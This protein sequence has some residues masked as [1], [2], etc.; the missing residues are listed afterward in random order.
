MMKKLEF[1]EYLCLLLLGQNYS[2]NFYYG[3]MWI[4]KLS[5]L[6]VRMILCSITASIQIAEVV[7]ALKTICIATNLF[8]LEPTFINY[9]KL[10]CIPQ[11]VNYGN[12][13]HIWMNSCS[14]LSRFVWP[15]QKCAHKFYTKVK[16]EAK[17]DSILNWMCNKWNEKVQQ[18]DN[19]CVWKT[20]R[21]MDGLFVCMVW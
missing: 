9:S 8:N 5:I 3:N 2:V 19:L 10:N 17:T 14:C 13:K 20:V 4:L 11:F 16:V 15:H 1:S 6:C 12:H 21:K 18:I 7:V